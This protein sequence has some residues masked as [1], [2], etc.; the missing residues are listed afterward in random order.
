MYRELEKISDVA[1]YVQLLQSDANNP[2]TNNE[3]INIVLY[4]IS[5]T[6]STYNQIL[7]LK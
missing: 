5:A 1:K 4:K 7:N 3:R 2:Y 6:L